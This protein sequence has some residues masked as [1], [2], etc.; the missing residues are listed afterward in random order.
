M[1]EGIR[2]RR[3]FEKLLF[4]FVFASALAATGCSFYYRSDERHSTA[5][6]LVT[7]LLI[8]AEIPLSGLESNIHSVTTVWFVSGTAT[9]VKTQYF[10]RDGAQTPP[11]GPAATTQAAGS[12]SDG[13]LAASSRLG[14]VSDQSF[15]AVRAIN[16]SDGSIVNTLQLPG[17]GSPLGIAITPDGKFLWVCEGLNPPS[18]S[19]SEIEIIDTSTFKIVGSI[20]LGPL[21]A[22]TWI[23]MAP[24]GKT[25]YVTNNG[26]NHL[27]GSQA[28]NS[29][30]ILDVA[31][32]TVSGQ[33]LPPVINAQR[34]PDR[35]SFDRLA[36]SPDGTL[37][38]AQCY[39][40]IAVFD[41]L[42]NTQVSPP[43]NSA[44]PLPNISTF[45]V[46]GI[47]PS[48][49]TRIVF[50]PNGTRAYFASDVCPAPNS[51]S[52][53]LAVMDTKTN[54][55]ADAVPLGSSSTTEPAGL[56]IS[57]DGRYV[58]VKE[59]NSGDWIVVD[60]TTDTVVR[61]VPGGPQRYTIFFTTN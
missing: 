48:N 30:L 58:V 1:N 45:T 40:G 59:F 47:N 7:N 52:A 10:A 35:A 16:L 2:S 26:L 44:L 60:T 41:T 31:K 25:A 42:T 37:L 49:E 21:V 54:L 15:N 20:P 19:G 8:S 57:S 32:R 51:N 29:I 12:K 28:V 5:Y 9:E 18:T 39:F 34:G 17:T 33:I 14:Y 36:V 6:N 27:G 3:T 46:P 23:A 4:A 38:Y 43:P 61:R 22:A 50:H 56:S 24:D 11:S 13:R 53:C 55:I